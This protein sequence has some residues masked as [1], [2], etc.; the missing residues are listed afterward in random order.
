[1]RFRLAFLVPL[2]VLVLA[3]A[4]A[5]AQ[6]VL[7]GPPDGGNQKASV[8]QG[9]GLVE[10]EVRYS[11]PDVHAQNGSDRRGKIWGGL[12][13]W[14]YANLGFGT[15]GD[16]CP[17][18]GGANQNT[19]FRVSH[20]VLVEGQPLA[21]GSY[22]LHFLPG[23]KEWTVIFSKNFEAWGSFSYD[24]ADDAMRVQA[25]PKTHDYREWLTYEFPDRGGDHATL[26]LQWED[27]A[28]PIHITVPN[29][30]E[31][32]YAKMKRE[33]ENY[34]GFDWHGWLQ[35]A[36]FL[37]AHQMH[38]DVAETWARVAI[39]PSFR[40]ERN[41]QTLSVLAEALRANGKSD[42]AK[43][44]LDQAVDHPIAT[45]IAV[46]QLVRPWIGQGRAADALA[47]LEHAEA[48]FHGEW[49]L[50][51]ATGRAYAQLGDA[52]H[53]LEHLRKALP[54]APDEPNRANLERLI[55]KLESGDTA[56]N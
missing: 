29:I 15:C 44:T 8:T 37:L 18:R 19:V 30:N 10:V 42:E 55:A 39:E 20:D 14:G 9:I 22:G 6:F 47:L 50:E 25:T 16:K 34:Q 54:Q 13:P 41:F 40:G 26:E 46:Y 1:M 12:V 35:G 3:T 38:P 24:E 51:V 28:L 32:Y 52:A 2:A 17:W 49:P 11:S 48:R 21:A 53:A 43:A 45:P 36:Q 7:T 4:P 31:L 5:G 23:E 33:L 27:L 56:I